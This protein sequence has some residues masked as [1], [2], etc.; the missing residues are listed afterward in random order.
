MTTDPSHKIIRIRSLKKQHNL[1]NQVIS[2]YISTS[3]YNT[4]QNEI[5][6]LGFRFISKD[7]ERPWGLW[8]CGRDLAT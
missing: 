7:F 2:R 5:E 6:S 8:H 1:I 4:F 3:F